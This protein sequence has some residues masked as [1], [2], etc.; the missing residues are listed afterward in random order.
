MALY[1][2]I[3]DYAVRLRSAAKWHHSHDAVE[4]V[5]K[6][7]QVDEDDY[8]YEFYVLVQVLASLQNSYHLKYEHAHARAKVFPKGHSLKRNYPYFTARN[9]SE[10]SKIVFQ[11]CPGTRV[12]NC[13]NHHIHP[14]ISFQK[15]SST[16]E[17]T[18]KDLI[19]VLD[20]KHKK[21]ANARVTTDDVKVFV[22]DLIEY[23]LDCEGISIRFDHPCQGLLRSA[24]ITNG[25]PHL[26]DD[27]LLI[28]RN[29]LIIYN[30][31]PGMEPKVL[32]P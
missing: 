31:Y 17:P 6:S 22:L 25:L 28:A 2:I 16:F 20:A 19:M 4:H 13:H 10:E 29:A 15:P 24:I 23:Q 14:D 11:I 21:R 3:K 32:P 26:D 1:S 7:D 18:G 5:F 8:V 9:I 12:T 27:P 30:F